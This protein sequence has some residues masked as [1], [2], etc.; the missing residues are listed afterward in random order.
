MDLERLRDPF[1]Q[2]VYVQ[3]TR[4]RSK[5]YEAWKALSSERAGSANLAGLKYIRIKKEGRSTKTTSPCPTP[6][7]KEEGEHVYF[8]LNDLVA[9]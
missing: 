2:F 8:N 4:K 9:I 7:E 5:S 3:R 6:S 1:K